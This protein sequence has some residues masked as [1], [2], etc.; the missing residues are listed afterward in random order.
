MLKVAAGAP[1]VRTL[2][3]KWHLERPKYEPF[4]QNGSWSTQSTNPLLEMAAGAQKVLNLW[5]RCRLERPRYNLRLTHC[6]LT[7][8]LFSIMRQQPFL[9]GSLGRCPSLLLFRK[10]FGSASES[11]SENASENSSENAVWGANGAPQRGEA[12]RGK[13]KHG[14]QTLRDLGGFRIVRSAGCRN[15]NRIN[16]NI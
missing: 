4:A 3:S 9:E 1:K 8:G 16:D 7:F 12:G 2:C 13:V 10:R 15:G 11:A 14:E 5:P 6:A